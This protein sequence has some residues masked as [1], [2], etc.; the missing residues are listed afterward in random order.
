MNKVYYRL[1]NFMSNNQ[2]T[3]VFLFLLLFFTTRLWIY[4]ELSKNNLLIIESSD[5]INQ[6]FFELFIFNHTIPNGHLILEK[7]ISLFSLET[8]F[9]FYKL[10]IFYSLMLC[11]FL[12]DL[13]K[14]IQ[15]KKN[16]RLLILILVS[17]ILIPYEIWRP[18]HHDHIN[19]FLIAYL[20]WSTF[21]FISYKKKLNHIILSLILLNFFYTLAFVYSI[22][23]FIFLYL[24]NKLNKIK[25]DNNYF[26]KFISV[27]TIIF[28]IFLKNYLSISIFSPTSMGGANLIQRTVHAIGE[29]KYKSLIELKKDR[30]PSW[31]TSITQQILDK[32][33][34]I[35]MADIRISNL[36]HGKLDENLF[37]NYQKQEKIIMNSQKQ[38]IDIYNYIKKDKKILMNKKWLYD[39]GYKQNLISTKYQSLG[40]IIFVE[41]CKLYPKEMM[42]GKLGNKGIILTTFQMVSYG[43][44]LPNYY[45]SDSRYTNKFYYYLY[46]IFRFLIIFILMLT[47]FVFLKKIIFNSL[48]KKDLFYI[49][50]IISL[51]SVT[52]ITST[53]TC[54]ENPRMFVMQF[55]LISI[56][57]I[58]NLDYFFKN[59]K[60]FNK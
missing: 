2:Y 40:K 57:C 36:A 6:D 53:I 50:L 34:K 24:H 49:L 31:W 58:M 15:I 19:I 8:V 16:Y 60:E 29:E 39:Y 41:A 14:K 13:T 56:I 52:V 21:Y 51:L 10:N 26:L 59:K 17:M 48:S 33:K 46:I 43:G 37:L 1:I 23:I 11:Y 28:L 22:L 55:Y 7:F 30:F 9:L 54:C 35:E 38:E 44:L 20:F 25:L 18:N 3:K 27:F 4:F 45:E 12:N 5:Y 47:P 42:F 32:N